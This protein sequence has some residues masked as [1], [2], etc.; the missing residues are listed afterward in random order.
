MF[1]LSNRFIPLKGL[2]I[3]SG[4]ICLIFSLGFSLVVLVITPNVNA[5]QSPT[6]ERAIINHLIVLGHTKYQDAVKSAQRLNQAI[7]QFLANPTASTHNQAKLAYRSSRVAYQQTEAFRFAHPE[8]DDLEGRVNAWPLDE[9]FVDYV[10]PQYKGSHTF[11]TANLIAA[12]SLKIGAKTLNL[13][14]FDVRTLREL[15]EFAGHESNVATGYHAIEFLLWGQDL[16][17]ERYGAGMRSHT[18]YLLQS[19]TGGHCERRRNY[20]LAVTKLLVADLTEMQT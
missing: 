14:H 4:L 10:T 13:K 16:S 5:A 6:P 18:D 11:A 12:D 3:T 17:G 8:V 7:H 15:H 1:V 2:N 9:G 20:L 19:C